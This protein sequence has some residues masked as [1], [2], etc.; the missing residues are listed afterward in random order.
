MRTSY[1]EYLNLGGSLDETAFNIY[2]SEA[3]AEIKKQTFARTP[4]NNDCYKLCIVKLIEILSKADILQDKVQSFS[5]DGVSVNMVVYDNSVYSALINETIKRY[6]SNE[7]DI[8]GIPML[9]RGV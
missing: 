4:Q 7:L 8:N 6:M 1:T 9:Y 2:Y 5:N 3:A